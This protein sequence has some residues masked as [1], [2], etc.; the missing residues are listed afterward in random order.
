MYKLRG[1]AKYK[2]VLK[3]SWTHGSTWTFCF[4]K[5]FK[6]VTLEGIV[7]WTLKMCLRYWKGKWLACR[8]NGKI[9]YS[10]CGI[11]YSLCSSS[12]LQL[13]TISVLLGIVTLPVTSDPPNTI[14]FLMP[15]P[16]ELIFQ[17]HL[18]FLYFSFLFAH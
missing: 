11:Q 7:F 3:C 1:L 15:L 14:C 2:I 6:K 5:S 4:N 16:L 9:S 18:S 8:I 10:Y 12:R 13:Y 17:C